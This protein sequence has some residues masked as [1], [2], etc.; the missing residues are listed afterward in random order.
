MGTLSLNMVKKID[1]SA[2]MSPRKVD[3]DTTVR[4][5]RQYI[6]SSMRAYCDRFHYTFEEDM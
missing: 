1:A 2:F 6:H 4:K 5:L 3:I